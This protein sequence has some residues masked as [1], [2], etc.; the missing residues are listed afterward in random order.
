MRFIAAGHK[1][2]AF[3]QMI[4]FRSKFAWLSTLT[5]R[6]SGKCWNPLTIARTTKIPS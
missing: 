2:R 1:R 5:A 3:E 4:Q 6:Q